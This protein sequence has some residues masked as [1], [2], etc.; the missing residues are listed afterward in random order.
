MQ[1]LDE[2]FAVT[3]GRREGEGAKQAQRGV[4]GEAGDAVAENG[5]RVADAIGVSE[6]A[7]E[8]EQRPR[9]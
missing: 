3:S 2:G 8:L 4:V 1:N 5:E 9:D 7:T 6:R